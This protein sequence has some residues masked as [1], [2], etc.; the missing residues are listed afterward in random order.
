MIRACP[1]FSG[2][3]GNS[4]YVSDGGTSVLVDAG[5]CGRTIENALA[6]IDVMPASLAAIL[7]THEH[8][9]HVRG[10]GVM[11]RRYNLPVYVNEETWRAMCLSRGLGRIDTDL[12][13]LYPSGANFRIGGLE[14]QS[15]TVPHDA[16]DPVGYRISVAGRHVS[17]FTDLGHMT[18]DLT[19]V[20]AG[21][22][23]VFFESNYDSDM[24]YQGS[25]PWPLKRR[26]DG[27]HGH[28]SNADCAAVLPDLLRGG[29][30]RFV[31]SHLSKENNTPALARASAVAALASCGAVEGSDYLLEVAPR[32]A[33]GRIWEL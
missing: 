32:Y 1:L 19:T 21:S 11:M 30:K 14:V 4:I 20:L 16:A 13:H 27:R 12:V 10:V 18:P 7:V 6:A 29:V 26:I 8:I 24:L 31:L 22:D 2:S 28:L 5:H 3:S 33:P 17:I 25:Y 15:V 9:D 23:L